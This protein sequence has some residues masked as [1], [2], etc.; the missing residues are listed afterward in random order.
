M[1]KTWIPAVF[2]CTLACFALT[3]V[4]RDP[5]PAQEKPAAAVQKWEYKVVQKAVAEL[6][7]K[8]AVAEFN[9]LGAEGWEL[10]TTI[11]LTIRT[12]PYGAFIFKRPKR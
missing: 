3:L 9:G 12:M 5:A 8:D 7:E 10:S 11:S 4:S 1:N 6:N 2:V